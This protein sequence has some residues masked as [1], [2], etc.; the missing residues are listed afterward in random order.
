MPNANGCALEAHIL[1]VTRILIFPEI[2][3]TLHN[4]RLSCHIHRVGK[5][6]TGERTVVALEE[7]KEHAL[8]ISRAC[9]TQLPYLPVCDRTHIA[10]RDL[11]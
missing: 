9:V 2:P 10:L 6:P 4:Q 1:V 8:P 7:E 3:T 11:D 5:D